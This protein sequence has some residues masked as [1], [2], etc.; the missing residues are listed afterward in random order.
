MKTQERVSME[1]KAFFYKYLQ[2]FQSKPLEFSVLNMH[3]LTENMDSVTSYNQTWKCPYLE[4][5]YAA[6]LKMHVL[7]ENMGSDII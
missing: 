2:R 5:V 3:V 6:V 4:P 7:T 1:M